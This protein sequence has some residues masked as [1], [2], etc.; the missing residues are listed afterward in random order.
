MENQEEVRHGEKTVRMVVSF[1]ADNLPNRKMAW[2]RGAVYALTN[3]FRGIRGSPQTPMKMFNKIEEIPNAIK[4]VIK[5][6]EIVIVDKD[7]TTKKL[8]IIDF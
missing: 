5:Q 7:K 8:Q 4:D 6:C 1:F 3:R 2:Q